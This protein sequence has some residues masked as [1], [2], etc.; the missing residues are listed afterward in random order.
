MLAIMGPSN[1]SYSVD[2]LPSDEER[3]MMGKRIM[4]LVGLPGRVRRWTSGRRMLT[5]L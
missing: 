3:V 4:V 1:P 2:L 5:M